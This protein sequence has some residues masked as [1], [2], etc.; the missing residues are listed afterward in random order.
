MSVRAVAP[1]QPQRLREVL[2]AGRH[3]RVGRSDELE[4]R[5]SS[6]LPFGTAVRVG[7]CARFVTPEQLRGVE[8]RA[9]F[10]LRERA[11]SMEGTTQLATSLGQVLS[12]ALE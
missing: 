3:A 4:V 9:P 6:G 1:S 11:E 5:D 7:E 8:V 12:H 2:L 10:Q